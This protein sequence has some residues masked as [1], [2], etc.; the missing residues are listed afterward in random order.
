MRASSKSCS[1]AFVARCWRNSSQAV[2]IAMEIL[3]CCLRGKAV[4]GDRERERQDANKW[5]PQF[6]MARALLSENHDLKTKKNP[7]ETNVS[8][9]VLA[10][11]LEWIGGFQDQHFGEG[12]VLVLWL[13]STK[14]AQNYDGSDWKEL[15]LPCWEHRCLA[16]LLQTSV[17]AE[18][19]H[20]SDDHFI[21]PTLP[22]LE[23]PCALIACVLLCWRQNWGSI[24]W[25]APLDN[26]RHGGVARQDPLLPHSDTNDCWLEYS[27]NARLWLQCQL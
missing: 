2:A 14:A 5:L 25:R 12:G 9:V 27:L 7:T 4:I 11:N 13:L 17:D 8:C 21:T 24:F 20:A 22:H 26:K 16:P 15:T 6:K 10:F 3:V 23:I 18:K 1:G 19:R